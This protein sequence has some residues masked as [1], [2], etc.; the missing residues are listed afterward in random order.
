MIL[1][2]MLFHEPYPL[3]WV[4]LFLKEKYPIIE[5]CDGNIIW[6][7]GIY[8]DKKYSSDKIGGQRISWME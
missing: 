8:F 5:D 3:V 1:A 4:L 6:V 2:L 7:P